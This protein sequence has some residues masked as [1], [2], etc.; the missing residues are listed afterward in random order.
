MGT[1]PDYDS[2]SYNDLVDS[3]NNIDRDKYPERY[4]ELKSRISNFKETVPEESEDNSELSA[5]MHQ[6]EFTGKA[7][8]FFSIWIVNVL[9]SIVTLGIYSAWAKVRKETYFYGNTQLDGSS[10]RYHAK[11]M[12]ILK[13]RIIAFIFFL[14]YYFSGYVNTTAA[15]IVIT[16][17]AVMM[18]ALI[19]MSLAFRMRNS[20]YRNVRFNF[21]K[22]FKQV[23]AIFI[24]PS[25]LLAVYL[26]FIIEFQKNIV[27]NPDALKDDFSS[28]LP[29]MILPLLIGLMYPLFEYFL[30]KFRIN[31]SRFGKSEFGFTSGAGSFYA[32]YLIAA[33]VFIPGIFIITFTMTMIMGALNSA[34]NSTG[35]PPGPF[36]MLIVMVPMMILY[37]WLFAY[38][39]TRKTNLIYNNTR[40]QGHQLHSKLQ[41]FDMTYLYIT[42]TLAIA[43][44]IGLLAPWAMVRTTRY[45]MSC[46][47]LLS[48]ESLNDFV[49]TQTSEQSAY[50]EEIGEMFDIDLG[51]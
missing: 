7:G 13:G 27:A 41:V 16:A 48:D 21:E 30:V 14:A 36:M 34:I 19:V 25:L 5:N 37:L 18:P 32:I 23:Y 17:I 51:F 35:V 15:G 42:N 38:I 1:K 29:I 4:E 3:L 20:S 12:Q 26:Y 24:T 11:P 22:D 2:Y 10:F 50:G 39:Q 28:Y 49:A 40:I 8:E 6:F 31:H 9:L 33:A 46:T 47:S 43:F 45:K 44:S